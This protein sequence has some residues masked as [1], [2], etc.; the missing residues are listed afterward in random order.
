MHGYKF[1]SKF[2][3][4]NYNYKDI[5]L[6]KYPKSTC[7]TSENRYIRTYKFK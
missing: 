2:Y 1:L 6:Y 5:K 4:F 7:N 3:F